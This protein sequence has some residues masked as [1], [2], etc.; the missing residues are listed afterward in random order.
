MLG[1]GWGVA[2]YA[3]WRGLLNVIVLWKGEKYSEKIGGFHFRDVR[4]K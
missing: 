1:G 2:W 3:D 4:V